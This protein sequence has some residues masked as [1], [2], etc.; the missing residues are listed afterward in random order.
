MPE[1]V[2]WSPYSVPLLSSYMK[3][4]EKPEIW[5]F[6]L[7]IMRRAVLD[8]FPLQIAAT[9]LHYDN[10]FGKKNYSCLHESFIFKKIPEFTILNLSL[11]NP[12]ITI[13]DTLKPTIFA[14]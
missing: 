8:Q 13:K 7:I 14:A 9:M 11:A 10:Y 6:T 5:F 2:K 4:K 3:P 12:F 1:K